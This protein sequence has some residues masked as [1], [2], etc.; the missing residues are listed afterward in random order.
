MSYQNLNV[1]TVIH[2]KCRRCEKFRNPFEFVI[3]P[4]IGY[5]WRCYENHEEALR[6]LAGEPPKACQVC[7]TPFLELNA[8][9]GRADTPMVLEFKDGLYQV[10]CLDC[11]RKYEQSQRKLLRRTP[12]GAAAKL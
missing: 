1:R 2:E 12:Y 4:I 7:H 5:C 3:D 9:L 6:V 8:G 10:L 11:D